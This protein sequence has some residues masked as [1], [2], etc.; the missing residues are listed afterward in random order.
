MSKQAAAPDTVLEALARERLGVGGVAPFVL[1]GIG[2]L[3]VTAG[4]VPTAY[5]VTGLTGVPAAFGLVAVVLAVFVP[6]YMA[7]A[8][9]VP[10][11]G[12]FYALISRGLGR[13]TGVGAAL[14]AFIAY[15]LLQVGIYGML[16]PQM[17]GF[18]RDNSGIDLPW[19][20]WAFGAWAVVAVLGLLRV[21]LT[22][23]VLAVLSGVELLVIVAVTASG[24]AHPAGDHV[25]AAALSPTG[26]HLSGLGAVLAVGVLGFVGFEQAPVLAEEARD[27]ARTIPR[28]TYLCLAAVA[29]WALSVHYGDHVVPVAQSPACTTMLFAMAPHQLAAIGHT[30]FLTSLLAAAVSF[31]TTVVRY[32]WVLGQERVLPTA[33][34]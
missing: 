25:S 9:R 13:P 16:G 12:A 20:F 33:I 3:L 32:V 14:V 21:D 23:R 7:M 1:S 15:N 22:S 31:H 26:L 8:R 6:G 24:L 29:A 27:R 28:A 2:P 30:L 18:A 4:V 17:A 34:G 5:A 11:A 10:N 19:G